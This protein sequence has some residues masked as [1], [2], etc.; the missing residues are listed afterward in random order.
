MKTIFALLALVVSTAASSTCYMILTP[1]NEV[2][3]QGSSAPVSMDKVALDAE[4]Q[5]LVPQGHL[6]IIDISAT[7][8]PSLDLTARVTTREKVGKTKFD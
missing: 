3:W 4:V 2:V 8:C 6:I 1:S 5:K 7:P